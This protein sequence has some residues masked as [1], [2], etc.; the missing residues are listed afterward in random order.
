MKP[1]PSLRSISGTGSNSSAKDN[2][3]KKSRGRADLIGGAEP[4]GGPLAC[5]LMI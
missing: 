1:G 2:S 3:E 4:M 5:A